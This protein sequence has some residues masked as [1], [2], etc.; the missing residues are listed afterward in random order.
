ML[1]ALLVQL[2][3]APS[4]VD[5]IL[6]RD[7]AELAILSERRQARML[8]GEPIDEAQ[9]AHEAQATTTANTQRRLLVDL[10]VVPRRRRP[11][12]AFQPQI[13]RRVTH[14]LSKIKY[15]VNHC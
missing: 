4:E 7:A 15:S 8:R 12:K 11:G 5:M 1:D 6:A 10:G 9:A 2:P 3:G 14:L 13:H